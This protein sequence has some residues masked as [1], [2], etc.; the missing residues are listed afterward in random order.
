MKKEKSALLG[1]IFG[2]MLVIVGCGSQ[3]DFSVGQFWSK[4]IVWIGGGTVGAIFAIL[5]SLLGKSDK[6]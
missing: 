1:F 2:F 3:T 6:Q 5:G 4:S